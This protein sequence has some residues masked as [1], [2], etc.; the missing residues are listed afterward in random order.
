MSEILFDKNQ[1]ILSQNQPINFISGEDEK[2]LEYPKDESMILENEEIEKEL[3]DM[4][5]NPSFDFSNDVNRKLI[6]QIIGVS[7]LVNIINSFENISFSIDTLFFSN[8]Y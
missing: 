8:S 7:V 3:D 4:R 1:K 2:R 5:N 6:S